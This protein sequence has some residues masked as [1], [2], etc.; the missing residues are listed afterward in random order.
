MTQSRQ[1]D[2]KL[3]INCRRLVLYGYR[4]LITLPVTSKL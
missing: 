4:V 1:I 3:N 2:V